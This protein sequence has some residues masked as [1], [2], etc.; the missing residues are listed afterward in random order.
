MDPGGVTAFS[1]FFLNWFKVMNLFPLAMFSYKNVP[2]FGRAS[3][4]METNKQRSSK[5]CFPF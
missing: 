5:K 4:F 3:L 1:I 2:P